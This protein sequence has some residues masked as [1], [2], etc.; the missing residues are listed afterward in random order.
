MRNGKGDD[1]FAP[2]AC[3]S[4]L[5]V[6]RLDFRGLPI[7]ASDQPERHSCVPPETAIHNS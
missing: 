3:D 1:W 4:L 7:S 6:I 5:Y 2:D